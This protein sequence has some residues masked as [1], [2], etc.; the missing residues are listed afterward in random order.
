[1]NVTFPFGISDFAQQL[2]FSF[3]NSKNEVYRRQLLSQVVHRLQEIQ[4]ERLHKL[5]HLRDERGR[6][7]QAVPV[8]KEKNPLKDIKIKD[9]K[10]FFVTFGDFLGESRIIF[11]LNKQFIFRL[12]EF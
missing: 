1:V 2:D 7:R 10:L 5:I 9:E 8:C 6:Q 12:R 11:L 4:F 3:E